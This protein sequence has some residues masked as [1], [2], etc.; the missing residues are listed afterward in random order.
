MKVKVSLISLIFVLVLLCFGCTQNEYS[1]ALGITKVDAVWDVDWKL[2][3]DIDFSR[4]D[5]LQS[6]ATDLANTVKMDTDEGLTEYAWKLGDVLYSNGIFSEPQFPF[7]IFIYSNDIVEIMYLPDGYAPPRYSTRFTYDGN[8][9]FVYVD[10][11]TG[12]VLDIGY[13]AEWT[14]E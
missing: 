14:R 12:R 6:T 10:R 4:K 7:E 9:D 2:N 5:A 8:W 1:L 13:H 3:E 11:N